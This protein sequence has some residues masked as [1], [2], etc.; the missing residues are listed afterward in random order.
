MKNTWCYMLKYT[1]RKF[2]HL[3][4]DVLKDKKMSSLL[5]VFKSYYMLVNTHY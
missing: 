5:T 3:N 4:T 2:L 1:A